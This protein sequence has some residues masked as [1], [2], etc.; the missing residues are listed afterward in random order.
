MPKKPTARPA[1]RPTPWSVLKKALGVILIIVGIFGIFLPFLQGLLLV[2]AG[3]YLVGNHKLI[4]W[5]KRQGKAW[6]RRLTS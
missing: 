1:A 3:V 4:G 6:K 5:A 2:A